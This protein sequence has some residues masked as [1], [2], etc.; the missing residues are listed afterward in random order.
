V[1]EKGNDTACQLPNI[2]TTSRASRDAF[3]MDRSLLF[4][5]LHR[6]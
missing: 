1:I 6:C 3:V 4:S 2:G 5:A